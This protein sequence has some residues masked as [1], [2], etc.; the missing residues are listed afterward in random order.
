MKNKSMFIL[1]TSLLFAALFLSAC[2]SNNDD[3][4]QDEQDNID[5]EV[6]TDEPADVEEEV[7][8]NVEEDTSEE[9]ES[10]EEDSDANVEDEDQVE[11]TESE[12]QVVLEN[13]AFR[14]FEPAENAVV[15]NE[16]TVRGEAKVFE[17]TVAYEFEDGHNILDEGFVTASAGA[18]E[19]GAFEF[20]VS[21]D[22]VFFET[23][24]VIL[25][26]E[27]AKDGSRVNQLYIPVTVE[28]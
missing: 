7:E 6:E 19:W 16:F 2:G 14:I 8:E 11:D 5:E 20:T 13:E 12:P 1:L 26:E 15:G 25:Y 21:F 17:G 18:P 23:G 4:N 22:E 10:N 27:S 3:A 9:T 28:K 24:T